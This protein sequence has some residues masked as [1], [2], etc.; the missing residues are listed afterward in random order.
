MS[1]APH[2]VAAIDQLTAE[3]EEAEETLDQMV[4]DV[5]KGLDGGQFNA[6]EVA[7]RLRVSF[8]AA[9]PDLA[10]IL[11]ASALVRLATKEREARP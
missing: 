10:C 2:V 7:V 5:V 1:D 6:V 11:A 8:R 4:A 9:D 3:A